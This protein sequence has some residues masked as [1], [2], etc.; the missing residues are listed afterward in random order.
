MFLQKQVPQSL[1]RLERFDFFIFSYPIDDA[2]F[3]RR[4]LRMEVSNVDLFLKSKT[5]QV[6]Q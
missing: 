4:V 6:V 3:H 1:T 5:S 2:F